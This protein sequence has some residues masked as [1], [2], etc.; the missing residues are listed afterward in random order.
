VK[1]EGG[2]PGMEAG[3][4]AG[5][6]MEGV[7]ARRTESSDVHH[8][9]ALVSPATEQLFGRVIPVS[10]I[11]KANLA[12]TLCN[13]TNE[14]IAHAAFLDY[15]NT[16]CVD[17]AEWPSWMCKHF[18]SGKCTPLNTLFM[19]YF[20]AKSG[21]E[22]DCAKQIIRTVFNAVPDLHFVFLLLKKNASPGAV[23]EN[24]FT[25]MKMHGHVSDPGGS[26]YVCHRHNHFPILH[27]RQAREGGCLTWHCTHVI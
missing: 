16:A 5:G 14:I 19:H 1:E 18:D 23:L 24:I 25:K 21:V 17:Q 15:P 27:I 4:I 2:E 10:L 12:V 26:L 11:E 20:V 7:C 3:M 8:L 9:E 22:T 13:D 6:A